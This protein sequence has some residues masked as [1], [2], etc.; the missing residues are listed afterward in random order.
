MMH[1]IGTSRS[2]AGSVRKPLASRPKLRAALMMLLAL[3][4]SRETPHATRSCSSGT[5]EP[6]WASTIASAAAPHSAASICRIVGVRFTALGGRGPPSRR[7]SDCGRVSPDVAGAGVSSVDSRQPLD[8]R[9]YQIERTLPPRSDFRADQ[10]SAAEP[11]RRTRTDSPAIS[12]NGSG[13]LFQTDPRAIRRTI[14]RKVAAKGFIVEYRR[15]TLRC[16]G[17]IGD[18]RHGAAHGSEFFAFHRAWLDADLHSRLH[19]LA[20]L[21]RNI[22][23]SLELCAFAFDGD[24]RCTDGQHRTRRNLYLKDA[25]FDRADDLGVLA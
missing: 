19:A 7:P 14:V 9:H 10:R 3:L 2:I 6:W 13:V 18:R 4:P 24:N 8:Q 5:H 12:A 1:G 25:P 16:N 17:E 23:E 15:H 20:A 11:N 21:R 22:D